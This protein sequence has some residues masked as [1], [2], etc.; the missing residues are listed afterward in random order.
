MHSLWYNFSHMI[1]D[2][3][4]YRA[5][6]NALFSMLS[7]GWPILLSIFIT[8]FV[9]NNLG[10]K[11]YGVYLFISTLMSL[12]GLLDIGIASAFGKFIAEENGRN[13]QDEMR[14]LFRIG[15]AIFLL[16]ACVGSLAIISNIFIGE[17]FF[18]SKVAD[19]IQYYP[20]FF[21]A[22][23]MFFINS[24][25][26]LY[27][28]LPSALQRVDAGV[29]VGISFFTAQQVVIV[30]SIIYGKGVNGIFVSLTV[31]YIVFYFFY[32]R[33]AKN[34]VPVELRK[35]LTQYGWNKKDVLKYYSFGVRVFINNVANSS[36]TYLD[37]LL[38]PI[39]VGPANLT[40]YGI[41]GSVANKTP[42]VSGT[43]A[44]VIFPMTAS[45]EG[46]GDRDRTKTLYIRSMRLIA[47]LSASVSITIISFPY[48]MLQFWISEEVAINATH[49][50]II[51]TWTNFFLALTGP[52]TNFLVG[53]GRLKELTWTTV[54]AAVLNGVFL[55]LLLP[56]AGIY[57]A[58][59]AYALALVPY[60]FLFAWTEGTL[61]GLKGRVSY[62]L[63]SILKMTIT[64]T[65]VYY[66]NIYIVASHI[67]NLFGILVASTISVSL[68]IALHAGF[69]F[70]DRKDVQDLT[71]F[72]KS[73]WGN[74]RARIYRA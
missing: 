57:G 12:A 67:E 29:K 61:L 14:K 17:L 70:F 45:F 52:L 64:G 71:Y 36:L 3:P 50:L 25:M 28:I 2:S 56:M 18:G 63:S 69:G 72:A 24:A 55:L 66:F 27:V 20:S 22:G 74:L 26:S 58:A 11:E 19:Y 51:L 5:L 1:K 68:F 39:F 42:A 73:I 48:K 35:S 32:R 15:N 49:V 10:V 23:A 31:L 7:F 8:P 9:V 43:F 4:T 30:S 65:I 21:A 41:A 46:S 6:S 13:N 60:L 34:L 38:I 47:V 54:T 59:W 62:Y 16:I 44:N 53:M 40:Y 33:M 37:K